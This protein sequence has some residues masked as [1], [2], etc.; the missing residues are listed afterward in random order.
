MLREREG[1]RERKKERQRERGRHKIKRPARLRVGLLPRLIMQTSLLAARSRSRAR[2]RRQSTASALKTIIAPAQ[3]VGAS[4][5]HSP[6]TFAFARALVR[7]SRA[8]S[9]ACGSLSRA[10]LTTIQAAAQGVDIERITLSERPCMS[11]IMIG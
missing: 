11:A 4:T 2:L 1:E 5:F 3:L 6:R 9:A 8:R 10:R 7:F